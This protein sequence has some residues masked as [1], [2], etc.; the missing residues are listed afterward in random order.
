MRCPACESADLLPHERNGVLLGRCPGC[1]GV[2][3]GRGALEQLL[4][5]SELAEETRV[6][7]ADDEGERFAPGGD[8]DTPACSSKRRRWYETL[9]EMLGR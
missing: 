1:G 8:T 7:V 4:H 2:W 9:E 3:L 5:R 6:F